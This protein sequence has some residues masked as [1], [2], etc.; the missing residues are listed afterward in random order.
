MMRWIRGW[1]Q[2]E[3]L[4]LQRKSVFRI[5]FW[6]EPETVH[7]WCPVVTW[8]IYILPY[9]GDVQ[10]GFMWRWSYVS[11]CFNLLLF[12][13]NEE[14]CFQWWKMNDY[15][16]PSVTWSQKSFCGR[17]VVAKFHRHRHHVIFISRTII[18]VRSWRSATLVWM[19]RLDHHS[20]FWNSWAESDVSVMTKAF[21]WILWS[22]GTRMF[23]GRFFVTTLGD[24]TF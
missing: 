21:F 7:G 15:R 24:W 23:S 19:P 16:A 22:Y 2:R 17:P 18:L 8:N 3:H 20:G 9:E 6:K 1:D 10:F 11:T 13:F 12:F 14:L 4:C 5:T